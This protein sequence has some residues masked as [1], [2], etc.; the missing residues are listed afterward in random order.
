VSLILQEALLTSGWDT[1]AD[2]LDNR[3]ESGGEG[4]ARRTQM[5]GGDGGW[6]CVER[7]VS[8]V[9]VGGR[10]VRHRVVNAYTTF[11][12]SSRD[13]HKYLPCMSLYAQVEL[14]DFGFFS[15]SL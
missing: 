2:G 13:I 14:F 9:G 11:L 4:D 1:R 12:S 15:S 8:R 3:E 5:V 10:T 6:C 7:R